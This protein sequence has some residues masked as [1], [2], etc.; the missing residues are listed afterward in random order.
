MASARRLL[1]AVAGLVV[2]RHRR[3]LA[4]G[5]SRVR[6]AQRRARVLSVGRLS[7]LSL[8]GSLGLHCLFLFAA[9]FA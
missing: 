8:V 9:R 5:R 1:V 3:R 6:A 7:A 4:A 2:R